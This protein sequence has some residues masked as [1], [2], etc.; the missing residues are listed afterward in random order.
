MTRKSVASAGA[1][2]AALAMIGAISAYRDAAAEP[3]TGHPA[4]PTTGHQ[5]ENP[6]GSGYWTPERMRD[7]IPD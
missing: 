4:A 5:V 7:A 1:L 2:L 3:N 6:G